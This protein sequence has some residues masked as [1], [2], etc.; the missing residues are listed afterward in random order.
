MTSPLVNLRLSSVYA[1]SRVE[2][3]FAFTFVSTVWGAY[4]V[5]RQLERVYKLEVPSQPYWGNQGCKGSSASSVVRHELLTSPLVSIGPLQFLSRGRIAGTET[6]RSGFP[7]NLW[8]VVI[9]YDFLAGGNC[10]SD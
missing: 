5:H 9:F 7:V 8:K 3:V 10:K 6:F 1:H 2:S 4:I